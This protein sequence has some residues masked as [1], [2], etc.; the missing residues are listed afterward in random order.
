MKINQKSVLIWVIVFAVVGSSVFTA[1]NKIADVDT[2][3]L[4]ADQ[5]VTRTDNGFRLV[6]TKEAGTLA[7]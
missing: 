1:M 6:L 5:L 3:D 4:G 7:P 2:Y